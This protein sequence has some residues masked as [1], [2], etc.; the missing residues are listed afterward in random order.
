M[1]E[2]EVHVKDCSSNF[3]ERSIVF[4]DHFHR[5]LTLFLPW[6]TKPELVSLRM[7]IER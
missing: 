1:A 3:L 4:G 6:K 5:A 7:G 2:T